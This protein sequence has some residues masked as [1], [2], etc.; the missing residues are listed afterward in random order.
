VCANQ[1][2]AAGGQGRAPGGGAALGGRRGG[3]RARLRRNDGEL[4]DGAR[5]SELE[6]GEEVHALVLR[7]LQQRVDPAVV[8]VHIAE[9]AHV[10]E[11]ARSLEWIGVLLAPGNGGV[12]K[13]NIGHHHSG[14]SG[15][16]LEENR[17]V[18]NLS[19]CQWTPLKKSESIE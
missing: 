18:Q 15:H 6:E 1:G 17:S 7:L 13:G 5:L 8:A 9:G 16:G 2:A 14:N 19:L 10:P 3:A 4:E 11:H 12:R